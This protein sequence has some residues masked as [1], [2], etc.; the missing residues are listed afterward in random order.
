MSIDLRHIVSVRTMSLWLLLVA[1]GCSETAPVPADRGAA[2]SASGAAA[3]A[4][5]G[6]EAGV[7]ADAP[8][9]DPGGPTEPSPKYKHASIPEAGAKCGFEERD[10]SER[11][12]DFIPASHSSN[13][14]FYQRPKGPLWSDIDPN[15]AIAELEENELI[16]AARYQMPDLWIRPK[17]GRVTLEAGKRLTCY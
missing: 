17:G 5:A 15:G 13:I 8:A 1:S 11:P 9:Y 16:V 10:P 7:A 6:Q 3:K 4:E 2:N 14:I 12:R